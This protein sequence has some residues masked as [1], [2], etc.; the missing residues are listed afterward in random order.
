MKNR[1]AIKEYLL[2]ALGSFV[3][4]IFLA[5]F[6]WENNYF[7]FESESLNMIRAVLANIALVVMLLSHLTMFNENAGGNSQMMIISTAIKCGIIWAV[8]MAAIPLI[9]G[10]FQ[11]L[12]AVEM[13][14]IV[15]AV[16]VNI[17]MLAKRRN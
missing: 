8:G 6:I 5:M 15:I 11:F 17:V 16:V 4:M 9:R 10:D 1:K 12:T 7:K 2:F 13:F 14:C 3:A